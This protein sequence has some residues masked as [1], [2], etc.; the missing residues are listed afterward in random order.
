MNQQEVDLKFAGI[1]VNEI[2]N[3]EVLEGKTGL[4]TALEDNYTLN[5]PESAK[6]FLQKF[7][8]TQ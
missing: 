2:I 4:V 1:V 8:D 3:H 7:R 5:L 6:E